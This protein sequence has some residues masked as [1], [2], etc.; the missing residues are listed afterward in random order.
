MKSLSTVNGKIGKPRHVE[1]KIRTTAYMWTE[2]K[3]RSFTGA[4]S[5]PV[6][7]VGKVLLSL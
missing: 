2:N 1:A 5:E 7:L 3:E 4:T 6:D